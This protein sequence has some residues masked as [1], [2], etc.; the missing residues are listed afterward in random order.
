MVKTIAKGCIQM[1]DREEKAEKKRKTHSLTANDISKAKSK[2]KG[3]SEQP[4]KLRR[5]DVFLSV[6]LSKPVKTANSCC[7]YP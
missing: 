2:D 4:I 5:P 6:F 1:T 7:Y 3:T